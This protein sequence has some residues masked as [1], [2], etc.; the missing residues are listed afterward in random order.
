MHN[1]FKKKKEKKEISNLVRT[2]RIWNNLH[3]VRLK[4]KRLENQ[5]T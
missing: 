2:K 4:S 3:Q 5:I 1:I